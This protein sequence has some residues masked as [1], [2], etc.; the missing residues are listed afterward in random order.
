MT[1]VRK[2]IDSVDWSRFDLMNGPAEGFGLVLD[3]FISEAAADE[4]RELW[5]MMENHVFSQ[6]D[7]SGAA[8]PT[9]TVL[10]AALSQGIEG[11]PTRISVLDLLFHIVQAASY[12]DDDLGARCMAKAS[13]GSWL[14]VREALAGN[15]SVKEACLEVLDILG[16]E[17][18]RL[19]READQ[20]SW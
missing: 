15:V 7:I 20:K 12:R 2:A 9:L 1:L 6:D 5:A 18:A 17:Q 10:L 16:P 3:A 13:L 4:R 11:L 8:E 19:V 14:L